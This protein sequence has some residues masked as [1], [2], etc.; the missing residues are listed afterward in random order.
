MTVEMDCSCRDGRV[1]F[2][3]RRGRGGRLLGTCDGCG[4]VFT[5][6]GG[7]VTPLDPASTC[8]KAPPSWRFGELVERERSAALAVDAGATP[9][10]V[11]D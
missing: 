4:S 8:S 7:R 9:R 2:A 6:F 3:S 11:C 5:L 1:V 10:N